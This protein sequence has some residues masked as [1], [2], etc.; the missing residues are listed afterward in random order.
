MR[1]NQLRLYFSAV[2]YTLL[3]AL[4]RR[5]LAGTELAHAQ[6]STIRTRIL[7]IGVRIRVTARRVWLSLSEAFPLQPLCALVHRRLTLAAGP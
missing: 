4:R 2:A 7:K 1:A 6:A 5:G 3:A